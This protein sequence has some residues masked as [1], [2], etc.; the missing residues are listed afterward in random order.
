MAA[1]CENCQ[2]QE[3]GQYDTTQDKYL[4]Q[5]ILTGRIT[6]LDGKR[7]TTTGSFIAGRYLE[8]LDNF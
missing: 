6:V 4:H 3:L 5:P 8:E 1:F 7:I 2:N